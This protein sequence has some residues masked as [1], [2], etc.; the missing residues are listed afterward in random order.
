MYA[1]DRQTSDAHHRLMPPV[2]GAGHNNNGNSIASHGRNLLCPEEFFCILDELLHNG[3]SQSMRNLS[4]LFFLLLLATQVQPSQ[5]F[6]Q[7]HANFR[8]VYQIFTAAVSSC[9][10]LLTVDDWLA[11]VP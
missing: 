10:C 4:L 11:H 9:L 2:L 1:T 8:V 3:S 7:P 5:N 6:L